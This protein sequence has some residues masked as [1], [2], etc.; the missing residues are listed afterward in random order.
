MGR[1]GKEVGMSDI[2]EQIEEE[3]RSQYLLV[4]E[5]APREVRRALR[6]VRVEVAREGHRART[7]NGYYP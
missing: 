3:L 1:K 2:R 4:Y 5:A 6:T 7:L